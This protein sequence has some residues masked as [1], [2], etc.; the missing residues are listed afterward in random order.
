MRRR[1]V[2]GNQLLQAHKD[3]SLLWRESLF[4]LLLNRK[5]QE[6]KGMLRSVSP[7]EARELW[8]IALLGDV[9]VSYLSPLGWLAGI[10]CLIG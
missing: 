7:I 1:L 4:S 6:E 9:H 5:P 2:A 3:C 10:R 8:G